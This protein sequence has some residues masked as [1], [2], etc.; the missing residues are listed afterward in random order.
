LTEEFTRWVR[1]DSPFG[2]LTTEL[3]VP[4]GTAV[5]AV[6]VAKSRAVAACVSELADVLTTLGIRVIK[7]VKSGEEVKPGQIIMELEGRADTILLVE[8]ALLNLM[9]YLFGVASATRELVRIVRSVNPNVRVAATRKVLPG[10]RYLVKRAVRDGGGDTHRYS[11]SDAVIIKDNHLKIVGS[12][13]EAIARVKSKLS[14]IHRVEVEVE[15]V[16][17]AIEAVKAGADAVMLDNMSPKEVSEVLKKLKELGLRDKVVIEVSG[18]ITPE[19]IAEYAKLDVD[20][21]STSYI[22]MNPKKVDLSL[23]VIEVLRK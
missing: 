10:L 11:L 2:D 5:R 12:V 7:Y 14:F 3:V 13:R 18:G 1:E 4:E 9:T 8:R 22:T 17:E 6:V 21:I 23:E 20:V 19:N 16:E 15:D